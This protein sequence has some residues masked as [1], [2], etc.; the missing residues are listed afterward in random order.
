LTDAAGSNP[1]SKEILIIVLKDRQIAA[2][3]KELTI[4]A[5]QQEPIESDLAVIILVVANLIAGGHGFVFVFI[6]NPALL[7]ILLEIIN[8]ICIDLMVRILIMLLV[9]LVLI[10]LILIKYGQEIMRLPVCVMVIIILYK[11]V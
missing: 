6:V 10:L 11:D 9:L 3:E 7:H 1:G 5:P 8:G 2:M 4:D